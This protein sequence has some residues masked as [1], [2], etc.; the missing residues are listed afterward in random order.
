MANELSPAELRK[1]QRERRAAKMAKGSTR[2]NKIL[3]SPEF[4]HDSEKVD[5]K[6]NVASTI[7]QDD[8][9]TAAATGK[10]DHQEQNV[11]SRVDKNSGNR[12]SVILNQELDDDPPVSGLDGLEIIEPEISLESVD[13]PLQEFGSDENIEQEMENLL[14]KILQNSAHDTSHPH[15]HGQGIADGTNGMFTGDMASMFPGLKPGT[16][17][18]GFGGMPAQP[19]KSKLDVAKAKVYQSGYAVIRFI[20]V[21]VIVSHQI[22]HSSFTPGYV[23]PQ[24]SRLW[25]HFLSTE[26][27]LGAI[28]L[29]LSYLHIFPSHTIMSFDISAFGYPNSILTSYGLVKSFF[30]DFCFMIVVLG[31]FF[32]LGA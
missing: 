1:L 26:V 24:G 11:R 27:V 19:V 22:E 32:Y 15:A 12:I 28:Y 7:G 4:E 10:S 13:S 16:G 6:E 5:N 20:I 17:P 3:G 2:L 8:T 14:N 25:L 30:T 23:F 31:F 29:L 21:W 9:V 18:A